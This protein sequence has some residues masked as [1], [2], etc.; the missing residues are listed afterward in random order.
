[1]SLTKR[2]NNRKIIIFL[3]VF[4]ITVI[5]FFL[6]KCAM[7]RFPSGG[8]PDKTPPEIVSIF[9]HSDSTGVGIYLKKIK[10]VFSERM[11]EGTL[12]KS[13][14]ISPLLNYDLKWS[15]SKELTI[16]I[17]DTLKDDQTYVITIGS[18][19]TDEHNNKLKQSFQAAFSTGSKIDRGSISGRVYGL[20]K[21][22]SVNIFAYML[23]DTPYIDMQTVKPDYIS[24]S[25]EKGEFKFGFL[26]AGLYRLFAVQDMN[27]NLIIDQNFEMFGAP[28]RDVMIDSTHLHF[29]ALSFQLS[30]SDTT[31]PLVIGAK[32]L[33]NH[34]IRVRL[35]KAVITPLK[36]QV[37]ILDSLKKGVLPL[38]GVSRSREENFFLELYT[39]IPDIEGSYKVEISSLRDSLGNQ[40]TLPQ[41]TKA[42]PG[43][44]KKDTVSLK[45]TQFTPQ[46]S[47]LKIYPKSHIC[48][49][50]SRPMDLLSIREAFRLK[51]NRGG[52]LQGAWRSKNLYQADFIPTG[53][54][55][56]DSFYTAVLQLDKIHDVWGLT[57]GDSTVRHSFKI[58]SMRDLGEISGEVIINQT[59]A[60]IYIEFNSIN[61]KNEFYHLKIDSAGKFYKPLLPGG[62]YL[63][64][65]FLDIDKNGNYSNGTLRPFTYAEPFVFLNDTVNVRNRWETSG[66]KI[67][68]PYGQRAYE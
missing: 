21:K 26:K 15:A 60:P 1:M 38:F 61:K 67:E 28:Y 50:F 40:T 22:E 10:I 51:N 43:T 36:N 58:I 48:I 2:I 62:K 56:P 7:R 59:T 4:L 57:A 11:N 13:I 54:L 55:Q 63:I 25:G 46:D 33:N 24:Q 5:S 37:K 23:T 31:R 6:I 44:I 19:A 29:N 42:F 35:N 16:S 39:E 3:N 66:I 9:P 12:P 64:N 14:F 65:A 49:I 34:T 52:V 27:N 17:G 68:I 47:A 20:K 41:V 18:A 45:L 30:K 32:A 53:N 8:P